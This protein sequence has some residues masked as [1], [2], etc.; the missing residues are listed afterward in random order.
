MCRMLAI[1]GAVLFI[2]ACH[3]DRRYVGVGDVS[4]VDT[5][6]GQVTICHDE[7]DGLMGAATTRFEVADDEA[8]SALKIGARVRF[9]VR[10]SGD[11]LLIARATALAGG[12]PGIHDHTPHH[13]GIVGMA[14]M[15]HLE[16]KATADGRIQLY[17]TDLWR[18]PLP[19][20]D[21][22]GTVTLDLPGGKR[23]LSL[24]VVGDALAAIGPPLEAPTV[25]AA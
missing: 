13:G 15:I 11:Q 21:F 1:A 6:A 16:A 9:E 22:G 12:N 24:A 23:T 10:R 19:L 5:A 20:D 4:E 2:A 14:G 25:N 17:L 3:S 8:R 18:R 7:I